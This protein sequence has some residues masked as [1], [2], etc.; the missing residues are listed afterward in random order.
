MLPETLLVPTNR[1]SGV[2]ER[3]EAHGMKLRIVAR[4]A[5]SGTCLYTRSPTAY[6][7]PV[8]TTRTNDARQGA[9]IQH[10]GWAGEHIGFMPFPV[11]RM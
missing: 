2:H 11:D 5:H 1:L 8:P 6:V 4:R 10:P 3:A 7:A 9:I